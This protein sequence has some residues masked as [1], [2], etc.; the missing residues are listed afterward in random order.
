MPHTPSL[1]ILKK[2]Y[3]TFGKE[4]DQDQQCAVVLHGQQQSHDQLKLRRKVK[5]HAH[6][7][8]NH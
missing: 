8:G 4:Q 5:A 7:D 1:P 2:G 3:L 6:S